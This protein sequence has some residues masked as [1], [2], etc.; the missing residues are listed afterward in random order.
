M[1]YNNIAF[2]IRFLRKSKLSIPEELRSRIKDGLLS[3]GRLDANIFDQMQLD[4]VRIIKETTYPNFLQSDIY[5]QH[6]DF[7]VQ[8]AANEMGCSTEHLKP[9]SNTTAAHTP[10]ISTLPTLDEDKELSISD[11]MTFYSTAS[12]I[13]S[14]GGGGSGGGNGEHQGITTEKP[15]VRLTRHLLLATQERRLELRPQG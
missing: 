3:E 15:H 13:G 1:Y 14:G 9:T 6:I 2:I 4:I 11:S 12:G 10:T 5:I 8:L 7:A